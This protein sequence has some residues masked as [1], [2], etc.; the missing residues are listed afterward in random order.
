MTVF[1][2]EA[3]LNETIE[4]ANDTQYQT[5]PA[6]EYTGMIEK[7]DMP[8]GR[9]TKDGNPIYPL[10]IM[11]VLLDEDLK[12]S[13]GRDKIIVRQSVFLDITEAGGL[14]MGKG[15][16]VPL[17]KLREALGLNSSG[18]S[19]RQLSGAGPALVNVSEEPDKQDAT[20]IR[21]RVKSVGRID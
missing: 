11:W 17:G 4:G 10:D 3:F 2:P 21:N 9:T 8:Q 18:F 7:I 6:G 13:L 20:L 12:A 19:L 15:K 16:N 1:D 5:V 14:D